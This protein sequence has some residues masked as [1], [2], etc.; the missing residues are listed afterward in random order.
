VEIQQGSLM[1]R[2]LLLIISGFIGSIAGSLLSDQV[3]HALH[4]YD[5]GGELIMIQLWVIPLSALCFSIGTICYLDW[6]D[7]KEVQAN[8]LSDEY[9]KFGHD[10]REIW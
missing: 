8:Q 3:L 2:I 6:K 1:K 7:S 4:G 5:H 10:D 9:H